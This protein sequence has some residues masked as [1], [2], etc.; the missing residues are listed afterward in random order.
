MTSAF[1]RP[2]MAL[3]AILAVAAFSGTTAIAQ[4]FDYNKWQV[5]GMVAVGPKYQGSKEYEVYGFPLL[6]PDR[7]DSNGRVS[8]ANIDDVRFRL[9]DLY[10]FEIGPIG[11]WRFGRDEKDG[12]LLTGLG[13]ID[14]G[15]VVG[16]YGGYRFGNTLAS[17][18][19]GHQVTG[20]DDAGGLLRFGL[21]TKFRPTNRI[22]MTAMLGATWADD[23]YMAT[24]FGVTAAQATATRAAFDADAGFKDVNFTLASD[25]DLDARW[26]LKLVGRYTHLIGD[27]AD[28]PIV[29]TESQFYGGLGLTYRFDL[30]TFPR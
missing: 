5:G 27:A 1:L 20:Q 22:S 2:A 9:L 21:E 4:S 23:D 12:Q 29:E 26:T 8:V 24:N 25:I 28:S 10:G 19:Y 14:G 18:S 6:I 16:A 15:L 7:F 13:D 30:R 17:I 11:G 3:S